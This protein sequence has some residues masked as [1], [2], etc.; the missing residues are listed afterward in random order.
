M[1]NLL[2]LVAVAFNFTS[3]AGGGFLFTTFRDEATPMSEQ[4]YFGVSQD[5]C[6]W[7]ALNDG[8]PV[9]V[10][11]VGEQGVRDS[12]LLRAP[13]GK[14]VWLIATDLCVHR[15]RD[16][17]R[18]TRAGS[19]SVVIW[20]SSDLVHWSPP[21]L[22]LVAP[23]DAGCVWAPEAIYDE[24]SR[25]YLVYW[26][27]TTAGDNFSKQRIWAARTKDFQTFG[28]PFVYVEKPHHVIDLDIVRDGKSF[29]RF[30]KDDKSKSV[31]M[32][33]STNLMGN[34]NTVSSFIVG[35]G[36]N[37]E[38]P[39]CFQLKSDAAEQFAPWCLLLD[40]VS[41]RI[42]AGA[43]GYMPFTSTNPASGQF[44]LATNF[45]FPYPFRHGSVLSISTA[46]LH[47]LKS[48]YAIPK[49]P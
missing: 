35:T 18:N 25:D 33:I 7:E 28:Q 5:G 38:G 10:S 16:W 43:F 24:E 15:N 39:I 23:K 48:A 41:D 14:K 29:Y 27:S 19:R 26:A 36:K 40:N 12:F 34:W 44:T 49:A 47:R 45:N 8:N 2:T 42:G 6:K 17:T 4:I 9:L 1:K 46:E 3:A 31:S 30:M 13:D 22:A 20:E 32:E 37:F 11:N 21:R